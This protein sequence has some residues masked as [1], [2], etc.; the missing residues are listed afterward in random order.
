MQLAEIHELQIN[1][2]VLLLEM[3]NGVL[4]FIFTL[5]QNADLFA[6][7]LRLHFELRVANSLL[8]ALALS[9]GMPL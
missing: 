2:K 1:T 5:A 4:Q 7:N 3:G 8:I 6:L 9:S